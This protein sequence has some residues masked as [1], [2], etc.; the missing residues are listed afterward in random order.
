MLELLA[1]IFPLALASAASPIILALCITLLSKKNFSALGAFFAGSLI[2]AAILAVLGIF[3]AAGDGQ[4]AI[5]LGFSP[6]SIDLAL[7]IIFFAFGAKTFFTK[8]SEEKSPARK[9]SFGFV[10]WIAIGFFANITN[11]DAALLNITAI[12]EIF[13]SA[14]SSASKIGLL[15]FCDIFLLSP[16]LLPA[17]I[18]AVAPSKAQK[19]LSPLGKFMEKYANY[20]VGVI[21]LAFGVYLALKGI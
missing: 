19:I 18:Y 2:S 12:R 6:Y 21:F 1:K 7:G 9:K 14:V 5:A 11:F 17:I 4:I 3:F 10:K 15:A 8:P 13:N 16:I 20:I